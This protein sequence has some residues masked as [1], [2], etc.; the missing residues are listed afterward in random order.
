MR[1]LSSALLA[2]TLFL[3]ASP[4][5]ARDVY[6][7]EG[8]DGVMYTDRPCG[9][10]SVALSL[11][12]E[13]VSSRT[14]YV[15]SRVVTD[16]GALGLAASPRAVYET[17]GRPANM[18]VRLEGI[19]PTERWFYRTPDGLLVVVFQHGRVTRITRE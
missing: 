16:T 5:Y 1:V 14:S 17:M 10:G 12:P 6:R 2:A 9:H 13:A 15:N 18:N 11:P 4:A 8:G 3:A 7:C 19:T